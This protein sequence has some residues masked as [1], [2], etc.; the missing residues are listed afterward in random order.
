MSL[1]FTNTQ[2]EY[3]HKIKNDLDNLLSEL[4]SSKIEFDLNRMHNLIKM[5]IA[6]I[7]DKFEDEPH[8]TASR[9]CIGDFLYGSLEN[10]NE[11]I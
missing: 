10:E 5:K 8:Q 4:A 2:I 6:E 1:S 11:V 9:V 7:N 3:L